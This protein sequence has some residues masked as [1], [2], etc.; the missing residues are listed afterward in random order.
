MHY[1]IVGTLQKW[2]SLYFFIKIWLLF[3][4]FPTVYYYYYNQMV[5]IINKISQ[6]SAV[7]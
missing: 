3:F 7:E 6:A 1:K 2:N 5:I 4:K